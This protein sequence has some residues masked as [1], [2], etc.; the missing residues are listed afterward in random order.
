MSI[1]ALQEGIESLYLRITQSPP[2]AR[3]RA[4]PKQRHKTNRRVSTSL[5]SVTCAIYL[6]F[7]ARR[8]RTAFT[9]PRPT[10]VK[11]LLI[12]TILIKCLTDP[13]ME[14]KRKKKPT[15]PELGI[16]FSSKNEAVGDFESPSA[17][18]DVTES[19][20]QTRSKDERERIYVALSRV[21]P[22]EWEIS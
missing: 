6:T 10:A 7:L 14:V 20:P 8:K 21:I 4:C 16:F 11:A 12:S 13:E 9:S 17:S 15:P 19:R 1:A 22:L 5:L 2:R 18:A 3:E